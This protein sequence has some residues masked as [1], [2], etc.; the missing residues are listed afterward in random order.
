MSAELQINLTGDDVLR[1]D[2]LQRA[3]DALGVLDQCAVAASRE[4]LE[5]TQWP[6]FNID[7]S[8]EK[9]LINSALASYLPCIRGYLKAMTSQ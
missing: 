2:A 7:N 9:N 5:K 4:G 1:I 3:R 8:Q 6:I